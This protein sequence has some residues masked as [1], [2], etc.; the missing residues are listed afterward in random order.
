MTV[1]ADHQPG[2]ADQ[3]DLRCCDRHARTDER[4]RAARAVMTIVATY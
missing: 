2:H 3:V 4:M 1:L